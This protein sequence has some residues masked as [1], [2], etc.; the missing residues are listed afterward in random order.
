MTVSDTDR[1]QIAVAGVRGDKSL[2]MAGRDCDGVLLDA[3]A[4]L[5][6]GLAVPASGE[7]DLLIAAYALDGIDRSSLDEVV[8]TFPDEV[9][10]RTSLGPTEVLASVRGDGGRRTWLWTG[11]LPDGDAVLYQIDATNAPLARAAIRAMTGG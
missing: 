9:W 4:D 6:L 11:A 5:T 2:A 10:T 1:A 3:P 7:Q 8:A